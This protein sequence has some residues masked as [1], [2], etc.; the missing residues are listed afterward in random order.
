MCPM[1]SL[2][3]FPDYLLTPHHF[4]ALLCFALSS[5][6]YPHQI[7]VYYAL[8][9]V[10]RNHDAEGINALPTRMSW[11]WYLERAANTTLR[12]GFARIGYMDG[13]VTREVLDAVLEERD[14]AATMSGTS[15][16]QQQLWSTL[17]TQ[18][19]A[20]EKE[21]ADYFLTAVNPYGSEF[22]YDTTGQEEIVIWLLYF[23]NGTTN[24]GANGY[25][26]AVAR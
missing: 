15:D 19:L 11:Q 4:V 1:C 23:G 25:D 12:L 24:T 2:A 10:A 18:L 5:A 20:G 9:R 8:Y 14:E 16:A 22:S 26:A 21:R 13:T 17:A 6:Q 7:A 3:Y